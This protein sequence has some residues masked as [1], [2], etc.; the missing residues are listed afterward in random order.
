[1]GT[2]SAC[3]YKPD[4]FSV[5]VHK[6]QNLVAPLNTCLHFPRCSREEQKCRGTYF[7]PSVDYSDSG[8]EGAFCTFLFSLGGIANGGNR[9]PPPPVSKAPGRRRKQAE[10][11]RSLSVCS[12][13]LNTTYLRCRQDV[14]CSTRPLRSHTDNREVSD[15]TIIHEIFKLC[16]GLFSDTHTTS[17]SPVRHTVNILVPNPKQ[18]EVRFTLQILFSYEQCFKSIITGVT[19]SD[20]PPEN[21][22]LCSPPQLH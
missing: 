20:I 14:Y 11:C 15:S 5:C 12:E 1:M 18:R 4:A 6:P 16:S 9:V 3:F 22:P 17:M 10:T 19:S 8:P 2:L 21:P 13:E 7:S